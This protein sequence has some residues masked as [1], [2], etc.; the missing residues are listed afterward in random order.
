MRRKI[1]FRALKMANDRVKGRLLSCTVY[2]PDA[3]LHRSR[4]G[5]YLVPFTGRMLS[6]TVHEPDAILYRLRAGGYLVPFTP[7][8]FSCT[9]I[10]ETVPK[11]N[12][13]RYNALGHLGPILGPS[14]AILGP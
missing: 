4:A 9:V 1:G 13:G 3:V 10:L 12:G 11:R 2:G 7:R 6:C 14:W 8:M 5:C